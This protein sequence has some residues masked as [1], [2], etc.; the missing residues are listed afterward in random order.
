MAS[1]ISHLDPVDPNGDDERQTTKL[2]QPSLKDVVVTDLT[3]KIEWEEDQS[4]NRKIKRK[5]YT[6]FL[7]VGNLSFILGFSCCCIAIS[8]LQSQRTNYREY[9]GSSQPSPNMDRK[10]D[11]SQIQTMTEG[12]WFTNYWLG[13]DYSSLQEPL[14]VYDDDDTPAPP[15]KRSFMIDIK[16]PANLR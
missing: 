4:S 9:Y 5:I 1:T 3:E 15:M 14:S 13:S 11:C 8:R 16:S 6:R 7:N 2:V 12:R 10:F